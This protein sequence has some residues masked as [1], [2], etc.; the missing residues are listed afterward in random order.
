VSNKKI[1][2]TVLFPEWDLHLI[3]QN[4]P[5]TTSVFDWKLD[6]DSAVG[7]DFRVHDDRFHGWSPWASLLYGKEWGCENAECRLLVEVFGE[8]VVRFFVV[9]AEG[10]V[11]AVG[12]CAGD[13]GPDD[14]VG[15][16]FGAGDGFGVLHQESAD[17][18][19]AGGFVDDEGDDF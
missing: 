6:S 3:L 13:V 1:N 12:V 2:R 17:A 9:V 18:L 10:L 14:D 8:E 11:E 5:A 15:E 7:G 4:P 19:A 16:A